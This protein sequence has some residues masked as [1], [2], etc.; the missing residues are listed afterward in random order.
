MIVRADPAQ[1]GEIQQIW[2]VRG[3]GSALERPD[4]RVQFGDLRLSYVVRR[5]PR[6]AE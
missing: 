4:G 6:F 2:N 3:E 5:P 1:R